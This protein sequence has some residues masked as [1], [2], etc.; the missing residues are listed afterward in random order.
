MLLSIMEISLNLKC[1]ALMTCL[2]VLL[3]CLSSCTAASCQNSVSS[4]SVIIVEQH[5]FSGITYYE[6]FT[7]AV[8]IGKVSNSFYYLTR[9]E[10]PICYVVAW[11]VDPFGSQKWIA[12]L[13]FEPITKSFKL[14]ATEQFVYFASV[15]PVFVVLLS[16]DNGAIV[17]QNLL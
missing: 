9:L 12:S 17:R 7:Y 16:T 14:D 10:I 15:Y 2:I 8:A 5:E 13:Q 6:E 1:R 4:S 3:L 11:K